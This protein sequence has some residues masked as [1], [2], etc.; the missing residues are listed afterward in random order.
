MAE[1]DDEDDVGSTAGIDGSEG[2]GQD[3]EVGNAGDQPFFT[4]LGALLSDEPRT[5]WRAS[6]FCEE[7]RRRIRDA[8]VYRGRDGLP[9]YVEAETGKLV[10]EVLGRSFAPDQEHLTPARLSPS[11]ASPDW[12]A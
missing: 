4:T 6:A 3:G 7:D 12:P 2:G 9:C 1:A 5:V 11:D 8:V 10:I